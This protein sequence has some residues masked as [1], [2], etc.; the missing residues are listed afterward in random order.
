MQHFIVRPGSK[1]HGQI[2]HFAETN[3]V[4]SSNSCGPVKMSSVRIFFLSSSFPHFL[5]ASLALS[6]RIHLSHHSFAVFQPRGWRRTKHDTISPTF[7]LQ[8]SA[9]MDEFDLLFSLPTF[10]FLL[11]YGI[12]ALSP[13]LRVGSFFIKLY[14]NRRQIPYWFDVLNSF[15]QE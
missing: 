6:P 12:V 11:R 15:L 9:E 10:S 3:F 4:Q 7:F 5:P 2:R 8:T 14:R 13:V 1:V